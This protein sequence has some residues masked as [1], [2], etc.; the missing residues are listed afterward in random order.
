MRHFP[1]KDPK[2]WAAR[3]TLLGSCAALDKLKGPCPTTPGLCCVPGRS[4]CS[5]LAV[6]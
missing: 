4:S 1:S 2:I 6:P 5:H 3:G